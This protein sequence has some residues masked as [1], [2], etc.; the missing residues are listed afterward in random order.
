M[1]IHTI[2]YIYTSPVL[3]ICLLGRPYYIHV[4][5]HIYLEIYITEHVEQS[6]GINEMASVLFIHTYTQKC[7]TVDRNSIVQIVLCIIILPARLR[8]SLRLFYIGY[9]IH[10]RRYKRFL[11]YLPLPLHVAHCCYIYI[12]SIYNITFIFTLFILCIESAATVLILTV[13]CSLYIY[14]YEAV[15]CAIN[16]TYIVLRIIIENEKRKHYISLISR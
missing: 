12:R 3:Y 2:I 10:S 15:E 6:S 7:I 14:S 9:P 8:R 11:S 4:I 1:L 16:I 5:L 13:Y